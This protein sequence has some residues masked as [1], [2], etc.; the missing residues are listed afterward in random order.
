MGESVTVDQR[1]PR[2]SLAFQANAPR[3]A[4]MVLPLCVVENGSNF[5]IPMGF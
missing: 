3:A 4:E 2:R 5:L 1:R